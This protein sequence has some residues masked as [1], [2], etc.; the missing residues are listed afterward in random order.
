MRDVNKTIYLVSCVSKKATT[1]TSPIGFGR[2]KPTLCK[3]SV[4]RIGGSS[5]LQNTILSLQSGCYV[6]TKRPY[7]ESSKQKNKSEPERL[8]PKS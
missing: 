1:Y 6:P 2:P 4:P 5:F 7:C 3:S 8:L